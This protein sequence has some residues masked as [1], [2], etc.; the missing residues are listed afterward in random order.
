VNTISNQTSEKDKNKNNEEEAVNIE[1]LLQD[2][3]KDIIR[4]H[5]STN[6]QTSDLH[7]KSTLDILTVLSLHLIPYL[8]GNRVNLGDLHQRNRKH[9][10]Y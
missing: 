9:R 4:V 2:L 1:E 7:A 10:K 3:K 6:K 8:L 5:A